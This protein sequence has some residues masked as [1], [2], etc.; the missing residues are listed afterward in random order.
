MGGGGSSFAY[1]TGRI[2]GRIEQ[3]KVTENWIMYKLKEGSFKTYILK[4]IY[5][6]PT[7]THMYTN[8]F[9]VMYSMYM[10]LRKYIT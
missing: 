4:F 7:H 10:Y 9:I 3:E 6:T 1:S 8:T 2:L 5:N